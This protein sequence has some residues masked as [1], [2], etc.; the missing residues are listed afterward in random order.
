MHGLTSSAPEANAAPPARQRPL[1]SAPQESRHAARAKPT[2]LR[3]GVYAGWV[4]SGKPPVPP[5]MLQWPQ[6]CHLSRQTHGWRSDTGWFIV[7]RMQL[8]RKRSCAASGGRSAAVRQPELAYLIRM[9]HHLAA[10]RRSDFPL[11]VRRGKRTLIVKRSTMSLTIHFGLSLGCSR[12]GLGC[13]FACL[14]RPLSAFRNFS[15]VTRTLSW[16]YSERIWFKG[17]H[18]NSAT[19]QQ[20]WIGAQMMPG[21]SPAENDAQHQQDPQHDRQELFQTFH[22]VPAP[23]GE[24][25]STT[26]PSRRLHTAQ[27][28]IAAPVPHS[29]IRATAK[30]ASE[31]L[32]S[33]AKYHSVPADTQGPVPAAA[34]NPDPSRSQPNKKRKVAVS[35][36]Y[37]GAGYQVLLPFVMPQLTPY[38]LAVWKTASHPQTESGETISEILG[39][40]AAFQRIPPTRGTSESGYAT[41]SG[42]QDHRG[43]LACCSHHC[44]RNF[45]RECG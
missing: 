31:P 12:R 32:K 33:P 25:V 37:Q 14:R 28:A 2:G 45:T 15:N 26:M 19:L 35:L 40:P 16:R 20:C 13:A 6:Q 43:G 24:Q 39:L 11:W 41:Q 38:T 18:C 42:V 30:K 3:A 23:V 22:G 29:A 7:P 1:Q 8:G 21:L 10:S 17:Q 4:H 44:W 36:A 27:A 5:C 34:L 9:P